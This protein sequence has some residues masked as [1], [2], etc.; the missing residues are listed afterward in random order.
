MKQHFF[1]FIVVT[2]MVCG[3]FNSCSRHTS[4]EVDELINKSIHARGGYEKLKD[5]KSLKIFVKHMQQGTEIPISYMIKPPHF[6]RADAFIRGQLLSGAHDGK[7]AWWLQPSPAG[8]EPQAISEK[9]AF[10]F[11]RYA[12]FGVL[13][14]AYKKKK[15]EFELMG[16]EDMDGLTVYKL[17]T[18]MKNGF[19]R[20]IYLDAENF[21]V[22]KES[23]K[24]NNQTLEPETTVTFGDYK[25]IDGILFPF[26][27]EMKI[28]EIAEQT[29]IEKIEINPEIDDSCFKMPK[30]GHKELL[31]DAGFVKEL[32]AHLTLKTAHDIFSGV[33]LVAKEGKPIFKKA[34]GFAEKER[35]IPNRVNTKFHMGSI[36]KM[37]TATAIVQL[38]EQ[39]KLSYDDF[40]G[41]YLGPGWMRPYVGK[42]VKISHL[43]T[44]TS[45]IQEYLN[46]KL[47]KSSADI[48]RALEDYKP[49]VNE[50]SLTFTP[51]TRWKY[52]N[53]GYILLGAI[54]E[55]ASG[56]PYQDYIK[57]HIYKPA[58]M[59]QTI[60]IDPDKTLPGV[61][62][63]YRKMNGE[64]KSY[65]SKTAFSGKINSSPSGGGYSTVEDLLKFANALQSNR[66]TG[67]KSVRLQMSA[68]PGLSSKNY[69]YGFFICR[70]AK[71]GPIAGHGGVAPGV[72]ANFRIFLDS[73][74]TVII[75]SN[76]G[77]TSMAVLRKI[78]SLLPLNIDKP[79]S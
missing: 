38:V 47:R 74:Y 4:P 77:K 5:I 31:N 43:L 18:T 21:L 70:S 26:F 13:F 32:D 20:F 27:N 7:T 52:C 28:G 50:K 11:T 76:Y 55:K 36:N 57:K 17:R 58:G 37:F 12:D 49:L 66:L 75:L 71:L 23:Y 78:M 29:T 41:K 79:L 68:K 67:K 8:A 40:A 30:T 6:I 44:H 65:W 72:S 45:G 51:G 39:G 73:G 16:M 59:N 10:N 34:Y 56:M 69:G 3:L 19:T 25:E 54:I 15:Q 22:V 61:A 33:V 2:L 42:T 64:G 9:Q 53:T 24:S 46:D 14:T 63:G 62:V 48:Y 1:I 60:D 35:H